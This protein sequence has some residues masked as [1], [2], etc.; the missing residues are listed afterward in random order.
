M[1]IIEKPRLWRRLA[2]FLIDAVVG[3]LL[4]GALWFVTEII[5]TGAGGNTK[6]I[7]VCVG[8]LSLCVAFFTY[9]F[10]CTHRWGKTLGRKLLMLSLFSHEIRSCR[11]WQTAV[12]SLGILPVA[13]LT[14]TILVATNREGDQPSVVLRGAAVFLVLWM[15]A[16]FVLIIVTRKRKGIFDFLAGTRLVREPHGSQAPEPQDNFMPISNPYN[17]GLP[18][19]DEEMFFN[20]E[21]D[22]CS[23]KARVLNAVNGAFIVLFGERRSGKTSILKQIENGKL[24]SDIVPVFLDVD[25]LGGRDGGD[26][27][28]DMTPVFYKEMCKAIIDAG[29]GDGFPGVDTATDLASEAPDRVKKFLED[30]AAAVEPK[31]VLFMLDEYDSLERMVREGKLSRDT[32]RFVSGLVTGLP[33]VSFLFTGSLKLQQVPT[34]TWAFLLGREPLCLETTYLNEEDAK[35]LILDPI[36]E[37]W[38]EGD[39]ESVIL[40]A[41]AE[42]RHDGADDEVEGEVEEVY[43]KDAVD[44]IMR[45][46][47]N[48]PFYIQWICQ[49]LVDLMNRQRR[50]KVVLTDVSTVVDMFVRT[51]PQHT[52]AYWGAFS[53]QEQALLALLAA[54]LADRD[55]TV[56]VN[57]LCRLARSGG[58]GLEMSGNDVR[59]ILAGLMER[60]RQLL[61]RTDEGEFRFRVDLLRYWVARTRRV[62]DLAKAKTD[63]IESREQESRESE[64]S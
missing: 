23:I 47:A 41:M 56:W 53:W 16:N 39:A 33:T 13:L 14:G 9:Y 26:S 4:T 43:S 61:E 42:G 57:V 6:S 62:E 5:V 48:H 32:I 17:V 58:Y 34:D 50:K 3:M 35:S 49:Q 31:K 37:N 12:H 15:I 51:P 10:I 1:K 46:T 8:A 52:L 40:G 30:L 27:S 38:D 44:A 24:G 36:A 11:W 20:R 25:S 2:A 29:P 28:V 55:D 19:A 21:Q 64:G 54:I 60:T 59:N 18:V 7:G 63:E 45:L 22:I